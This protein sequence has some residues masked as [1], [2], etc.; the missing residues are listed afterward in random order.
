MIVIIDYGVGNLRSVQKAF[1]QL[2]H[3]AMISADPEALYTADGV[4]L[5]GVGAFG[6]AMQA[7]KQLKLIEP[8]VNF[9]KTGKPLLGICLGMQLLFSTSE[10]Y[11]EYAG[12][13]LLQGRVVKFS[14]DR[15]VPHVGWNPL[16]I[17]RLHPL[18]EH[19]A[20]RVHAYF[21]HSYYVEPTSP[22]VIVAK[23]EYGI[24]FPSIVA[25]DNVMGVQFHPEKSSRAGLQILDNFAY[26]C[27][28]RGTVS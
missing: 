4:V 11:G 8:I 24:V 14:L 15:K 16:L 12:L 2:G 6:D 19:V 21:V 5:P 7:L 22:S 13:N 9:A 17:E 3:Q 27:K 10:E 28:E 20:D 25:K 1:E 26:V 18:V 23:T